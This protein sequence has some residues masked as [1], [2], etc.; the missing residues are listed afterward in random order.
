MPRLDRQHKEYHP[1]ILGLPVYFGATKEG[2]AYW[3]DMNYAWALV[4]RDHDPELKRVRIGAA[5]GVVL[6]TRLAI[7]WLP[8]P[9]ASELQAKYLI[10]RQKRQ[11][12][13]EIDAAN[14]PAT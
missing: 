12:C 5:T 9:Y 10:L 6:L 3:Q 1:H 11:A 14:T 8:E 13:D 4:M 2:S 7:E